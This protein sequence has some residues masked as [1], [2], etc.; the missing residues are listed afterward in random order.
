L[1]QGFPIG[2]SLSKSAA[3]DEA[4]AHSQMSGVV[5]ALLTALVALFFT[6][7]FY[8]LPEATLGAIVI[9]AVSHMVKVKDF[10][11]LYH[12]RRAD[13]VLAL[14]AL[15]AVLTIE[16]LQALLLAVVISIF[17]LVWHASKP[18]LS[19]L[20]RVP[21]SVDF[22][23]VRRNPANITIPGLLLVRPESDLFFANAA[24]MRGA[25]IRE[26]SSSADPVRVVVIDLSSTSDLDA[27]SADMLIG[28]HK[29]LR[30]RDVRFVL[31]RT[32]MPV[33]EVLERADGAMEIDAEDFVHSPAQAVLDYLASDS[34]DSSG[35]EA[36][37][38]GLLAA[39]DVLQ[40]RMSAVPAERQAA[41]A[42]LL[43][44]ID[45]EIERAETG[46]SST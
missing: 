17:A 15:L 3:N 7:L 41:L 36:L 5:A 12:V 40:A 46:E 26:V 31:T 39:R 2:A 42:D 14:V 43:A 33:R 30:E 1:F 11:H 45:K 13:F 8:A 25:I 20:G 32:I 37:R 34:A 6:Q 44:A 18:K 4:G 16:I 22:S 21:N 19:V 23:D 24:G 10:R 35:R 28:L 29:E 38:V 9:V 27:P